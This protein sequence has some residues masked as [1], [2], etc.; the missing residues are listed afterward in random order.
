[1]SERFNL[2]SGAAASRISSSGLLVRKSV[3]IS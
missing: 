3:P 1:V 2:R